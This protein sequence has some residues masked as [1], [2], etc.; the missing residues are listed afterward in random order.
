MLN[1]LS[2]AAMTIAW[3]RASPQR[4]ALL[5]KGEASLWTGEEVYRALSMASTPAY[6]RGR[7]RK[8]STDAQLDWE[9]QNYLPVR[10]KI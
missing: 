8:G 9:M 10:E 2:A 3:A 6:L 5:K 1:P 4:H 7:L